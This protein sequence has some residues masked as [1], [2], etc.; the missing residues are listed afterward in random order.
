MHYIGPSTSCLF[1]VSDLQES[2]QTIIEQDFNALEIWTDTPHWP[3]NLSEKELNGLAETFKA[4]EIKV[5]VH[6]PCYGT[7]LASVNPGIRDESFRQLREAIEFAH[8]IEAP[9]VVAHL[10]PPHTRHPIIVEPTRAEFMAKLREIVTFAEKL[11]VEISF[12]NLTPNSHDIGTDWNYLVDLIKELNS[13]YCSIALDVGHAIVTY[14]ESFLD[15]IGPDWDMIGHIHLSDNNLQADDHLPIGQG[16]I[17]Y[18]PLVPYLKDFKGLLIMEI[19]DDA[20][21][22][23]GIV[24]SGEN[25]R[26]LLA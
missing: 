16:K 25:V 11:Q 7:S 17:N 3:G 21:P 19:R 4:K 6:A 12:E 13:P 8:K 14:G 1:L 10:G 22:V 5:S 9:I 26:K 15:I 2:I 23:G 24:R 20:D 18:A